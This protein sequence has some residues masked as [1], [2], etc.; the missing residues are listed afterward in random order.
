MKQNTA[1]ANRLIKNYKKLKNWLGEKHTNCYRLYDRDLQEIPYIIDIYDK[2]AV[3]YEKGKQI[4]GLESKRSETQKSISLALQTSLGLME[5][6]FYFKIREKQKGTI[7]YQKDKFNAKK[8]TVKENNLLFEIDLTTYLDTGLFM[9]H[10]PLRKIIRKEAENKKVLNLFSYT[11]AISV[12][13]AAGG[14][15][16]TSVDLS[17]TYLE[18][19]MRNFN[20]NNI[21]TGTHR[22]IKADILQFLQD[23]DEKYDIIILDPPSFSN[24]KSMEVTW[25]VQRDHQMIIEQ[26]MRLLE[27]DGT[28]YF[29]TNKR[30]FKLGELDYKI[31]NMTANS[32]PQD[33]RDQKIHQLYQIKRGPK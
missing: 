17:N 23:F 31:K 6:N 27:A 2:Y 1:M 9:D 30:G 18:W 16:T 25:D 13:A 11:G 7:Q 12:Y 21:P 10:R 28:L 4:E 5:D 26:C 3:I 24:S 8:V 20:L 14:A 19:S 29:S 33:F 22:F 15:K 32:I